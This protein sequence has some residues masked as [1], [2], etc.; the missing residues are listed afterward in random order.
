MICQWEKDATD[1]PEHLFDAGMHTT[2]ECCEIREE[3]YIN[4][5]FWL[6]TN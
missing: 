2:F 6:S 3:S 4:E 5:R 1:K